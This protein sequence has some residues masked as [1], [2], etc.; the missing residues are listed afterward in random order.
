MGQRLQLL[1]VQLAVQARPGAAGVVERDLACLV[2]CAGG[3]DADERAVDRAPGE[4]APDNLVLA[5]GQDQRQRGGPFAE[6]DTG[7]L[8]GLDGLARAVEDVV[9]DLERNPER[10][11]ERA[12][13]A[14]P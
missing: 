4:R 5:R 6:V 11:T 3:S 8:P 13:L 14:P 7:D 1:A 12:E 10:E 9:G 2:Q